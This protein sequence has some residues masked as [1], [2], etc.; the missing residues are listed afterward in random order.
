MNNK[1]NQGDKVEKTSGYN[2]LGIV[3]A[4]FTNTKGDIRYVVECTAQGVEGML[5]IFNENQL[6]LQFEVDGKTSGVEQL[7]KECGF[8][9]TA[10]CRKAISELENPN[11]HLQDSLDAVNEL[12]DAKPEKVKEIANK[13]KKNWDFYKSVSEGINNSTKH[14]GYSVYIP[15]EAKIKPIR[16]RNVK[17]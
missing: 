12:L 6:K 11:Q 10:E 4:V 14:S 9:T 15:E 3:V 1:F 2:Y 8:S 16:F 13:V 5:H 7:T 17:F